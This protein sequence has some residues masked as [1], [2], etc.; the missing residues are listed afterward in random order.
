MIFKHC[1]IGVFWGFFKIIVIYLPTGL[2]YA[3]VFLD[4]FVENVEKYNFNFNFNFYPLRNLNKLK[5]TTYYDIVPYLLLAINKNI[6][7]HVHIIFL[8]ILKF[9]MVNISI[10][11]NVSVAGNMPRSLILPSI[12][13]KHCAMRMFGLIILR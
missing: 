10:H 3:E 2:R 4:I 12:V 11:C 1:I 13:E 7:F 6:Q 5:I 9:P 8:D